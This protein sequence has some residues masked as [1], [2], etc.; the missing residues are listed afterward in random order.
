MVWITLAVIHI[1][2]VR[3]YTDLPLTFAIADGVVNQLLMGF[4]GLGLWYLVR[5]SDPDV[6]KRNRLIINLVFGGAIFVLLW[7]G[8]T[9]GILR[10]LYASDFTI[11]AFLKQSLLLRYITGFAVYLMLMG[12]FYL[13][14]YYRR[15][16]EKTEAEALLQ[17]N[18]KE[19]ELA[20]LRSQINPHFLFNALN[21]VSY[22]IRSNPEKAQDTIVE[23][24]KYLRHVMQMSKRRFVTVEEEMEH[25]FQL[26]DIE[27]VRYGNRL[28]TKVHIS[29]GCRKKKVPSLILQ[30]VFENALKYGLHESTTDVLIEADIWCDNHTLF[31][32]VTNNFD[33]E[34]QTAKGTGRGLD[35]VRQR[36][37]LIYSKA[38]KM[39][40][41]DDGKIF[42]IEMMI[43]QL[44]EQQQTKQP[45]EEI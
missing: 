37:E 7:L 12:Y 21:S 14:N 27:Q 23:L 6:I 15:M 44:H 16:Q 28:D 35:N 26:L 5:Y 38:Y 45:D 22:L 19:S 18:V 31:V 20:Y 39:K 32:E 10:L 41:H 4:V 8:L 34:A 36:L 43:P 25:I 17:T 30:P 13:I 1:V 29:E 11:L 40:I 24:S 3:K 2:V 33:P 9:S 42:K